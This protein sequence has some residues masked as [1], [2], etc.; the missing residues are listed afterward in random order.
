MRLVSDLLDDRIALLLEPSEQLAAQFRDSRLLRGV[1]DLVAQLVRI[2]RD[3]KELP[4]TDFG[5]PR[6]LPVSLADHSLGILKI[7]DEEGMNF[8]FVASNSR[9]QA[10]AI[11][12]RR[13]N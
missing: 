1:I 9:Q 5:I 12:R 11:R 3:I 10:D 2:I 6:Q 8:A 13:L 7:A 4:A